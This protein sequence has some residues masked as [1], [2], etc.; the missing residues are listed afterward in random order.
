MQLHERQRNMTTAP[1]DFLRADHVPGPPQGQW[2]YKDYAALPDDGKRYEILEGVL[3]VAPAPEIPHQTA[4]TR[5]LGEFLVH[6][7]YKGL[8]RVLAPPTDVELGPDFVCEPDVLVVLNEH[9]ERIIRSRIKGA[10]DLIVE[11]ASPSTTRR[12]RTVKQR[13][14]AQ[15]GVREYWLVEPEQKTIEILILEDGIYHSAGIFQGQETLPSR[16]VPDFPVPVEHFF[17]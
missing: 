14:Y 7:E 8:G 6:V 17:G 11:V 5:I 16:I 3:Y 15:A 13:R 4:V 10:P 1:D 9:S 12:D 2:T